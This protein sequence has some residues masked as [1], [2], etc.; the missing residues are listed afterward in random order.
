MAVPDPHNTLVAY[1]GS[2][3]LYERKSWYEGDT[4]GGWRELTLDQV[5]VRIAKPGK[6]APGTPDKVGIIRIAVRYIA[7]KANKAPIAVRRIVTGQPAAPDPT[8]ELA[9]IWNASRPSK[10][11]HRI[12]TDLWI[13]G[14]GNALLRKVRAE[15]TSRVEKLE[16]VD[17]GSLIFDRKAGFFRQ[18]GTLLTRENYVWITLGADPESPDLGEDPWG[19]FE[20]DLRT[21]R[22]ETTYTADVLQNGGVIG[23]IISKKGPEDYLGEDLVN[24]ITKDATAATTGE[25]RGS[26]L[27][28][29]SGI[30]VQELGSTPEN[31][32]LDKLTLG[33]QS[34]VAANLQTALMV[35]GL[36]DPGKTYSNL[37]EG[38]QGTFETAVIGFH[39][40]LAECL[41]LDLLPD[42][43][44]GLTTD[45]AEVVWI[46]DDMEELRDDTDSIHANARENAKAGI[47]TPNEARIATGKEETD[48]EG[49]DLLALPG[50]SAATDQAQT[51]PLKI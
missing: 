14:K 45:T 25:K 20:D 32:A 37:K 21:L 17:I 35:L 41:A 4:G 8:A 26:V 33:A 49:A 48:Q 36:P 15:G 40:L 13:R 3:P 1:A 39:D 6:G 44:G 23:V 7:Q 9:R 2:V 27:V 43:D 16:A 51:T 11:T 38:K 50:Q 42:T 24:R 29:G 30:D 10:L 12:L 31:M 5:G 22:E 18:G 46:Y 47:W 19:S 28:V 34:R